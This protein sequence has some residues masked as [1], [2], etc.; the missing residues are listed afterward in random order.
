MGLLTCRS[1][2]CGGTRGSGSSRGSRS[3][4]YSVSF[5]DRKG[6]TWGGRTHAAAPEEAEGEGV[7][8]AVLPALP[9]LVATGVFPTAAEISAAVASLTRRF[10]E[11]MQPSGSFSTSQV[12]P[13]P[14][15]SLS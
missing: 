1:N 8:L 6:Q 3:G 4:L 11:K 12:L 7:G 13:L 5:E 9:A 2:D 14:V 15:S 10:C